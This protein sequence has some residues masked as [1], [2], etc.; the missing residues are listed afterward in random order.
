MSKGKK[1]ITLKEL[2]DWDELQEILE[3][4]L[5]TVDILESYFAKIQPRL[6]R[7][8][9]DLDAFREFVELLDNVAVDEE[10]NF[11]GAGV[12]DR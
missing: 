11:L 7:G 6:K 12:E 5:I 3:A 2:R 9:L 8:K 10:G 1:T 4:E